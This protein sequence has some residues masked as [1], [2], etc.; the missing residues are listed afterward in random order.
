[1]AEQQVILFN[2]LENPYEVRTGAKYIKNDEGK[3]IG[4][5][6]GKFVIVQP[7]QSISVSKKELSDFLRTYPNFNEQEKHN[8]MVKIRDAKRSGKKIDPKDAEIKTLKSENEE[9]K[10]NQDALSSQIKAVMEE[11]AELKKAVAK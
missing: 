7:N 9:L 2:T 8:E 4:V 1:M 6:G 5:E 11:M 3:C 10:V